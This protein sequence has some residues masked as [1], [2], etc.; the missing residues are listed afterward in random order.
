[1]DKVYIYIEILNYL[2]KQNTHE[3]AQIQENQA[4]DIEEKQFTNL[5]ES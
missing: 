3:N 1:M 4:T 2:T 5:N